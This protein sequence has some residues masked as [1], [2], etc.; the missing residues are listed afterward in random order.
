MENCSEYAIVRSASTALASATNKLSDQV[1]DRI[2]EGWMP[3]GRP[4]MIHVSDKY[5]MTQ[6]MIR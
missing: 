4:T 2:Q 1:N 5:V 3:L 6:S